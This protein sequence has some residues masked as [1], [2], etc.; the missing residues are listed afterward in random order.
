M[1]W[2]ENWFDTH[3]YKILYQHRNDEE[4][5]FF[6]RNLLKFIPLNSEEWI[7]DLACGRGRYAKFIHHLG[8]KVYGLDLSKKS[9]IEAKKFENSHLQFEVQ[10]MRN[11]YLPQKFQLILSLFTSFGY[12]ENIDDN[13]LVLK[14]VYNHLLPNGYFVLDFLHSDW[15]LKHLVPH[16]TKLLNNIHFEIHK[17]IEN[18]KIVKKILI[19]EGTQFYTFYEKVSLFTP[20]DLQEMLEKTGFKIINQFG[21]Y[22]LQPLNSESSRIILWVQKV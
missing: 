10:D 11:F 7:L 14:N 15:V 6:I 13:L 5:Q 18:Q 19:T 20:K 17:Y 4:A 16:E 8:Y 3:Y 1:Q 2:F 12:F 22:E 21:D 9:I